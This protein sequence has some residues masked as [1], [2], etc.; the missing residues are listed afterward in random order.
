M[1]QTLMLIG[2]SNIE[3]PLYLSAT[4]PTT[5]VDD[6]LE[7]RRIALECRMAAFLIARAGGTATVATAAGGFG[8]SGFGGGG[9][10][11]DGG[12][13]HGDGSDDEGNNSDDERRRLRWQRRQ[14]LQRQWWW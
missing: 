14:W 5:V 10:C 9:G 12:S 2:T 8:G 6:I 3:P 7:A 4:M 11:G 13:G 1:H